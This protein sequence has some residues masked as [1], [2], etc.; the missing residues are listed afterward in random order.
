MRLWS[1]HP[2]YLDR[3]GL[4][5]CWREALLAQAVLGGS[6]RG[7]SRHPQLQRFQEAADP[8]MAIGDYLSA[9][10]DDADER[11]YH[12]NRQKIRSSGSPEQLTVTDGQLAYEWRHLLGKLHQRSPEVSARW[13][14]VDRPDT[15]PL[16]R[17]IS[18]PIAEWEKVQ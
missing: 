2:R 16:F 4:T 12:F 9:V 13:R 7:Y 14:A 10:V 1:L 3:Q 5:A 6:T 11:G 17:V 8:G 15:H 18:G